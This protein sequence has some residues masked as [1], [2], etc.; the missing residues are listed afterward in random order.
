ML[1]DSSDKSASLQDCKASKSLPKKS[2]NCNKSSSA[3][4]RMQ[5]TPLPMWEQHATFEEA[6]A[7]WEERKHKAA[8]TLPLKGLS[9]LPQMP[10]ITKETAKYLRWKSFKYMLLHDEG[11]RVF[12]LLIKRPFS[13]LT[14]YIS[15]LFEKAPYQRQGDFFLYN[16]SSKE[17]FEK[18]LQDPKTFLILGFS[19]CQK[20]HECPSGRFSPDCL[21]DIKSPICQQCPIG[22]ALHALPKSNTCPLIIPTVHYIGEHVLRLQQEHRG[23]NLL[24]LITA[25]EMT[26]TMFADWGNMIQIP[27]IGLRLDGRIC[28]TMRAFELSERGVKP[29]LTLLLPETERQLLV[30]LQGRAKPSPEPL[31][32]KEQAPLQTHNFS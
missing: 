21:H 10:G 31:P 16:L 25:C 4:T 7:L 5:H 18:R 26:L 8:N 17:D 29:G 1:T 6:E 32:A 30:W 27:G 9:S 19:Y 22:K 14:S 11:R 2:S 13:H 15:S 24:F 23:K 28:N 12:R 20:P 3:T